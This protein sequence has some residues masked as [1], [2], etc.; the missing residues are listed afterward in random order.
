MLRSL[1]GEMKSPPAHGRSPCLSKLGK[2]FGTAGNDARGEA[3]P[4]AILFLGVIFTIFMGV[5]LV[6]VAM[7][8]T[9]VQ[10]AADAAVIAAQSAFAS[11]REAEGRLAARI[12]LVASSSTVIETRPPAIIVEEGR[13]VVQALI[14]ASTISPIMGEV[15][16][17]A[18]SCGPLDNLTAAELTESDPW[19]C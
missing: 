6:I 17:T 18:L 2:V 10:S 4:V 7:G 14:F 16:L 11:E 9:A 19:T 13:G 8:R 15:E 3:M 1:G 12:S 5:H